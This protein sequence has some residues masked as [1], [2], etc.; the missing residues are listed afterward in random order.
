MCDL[1]AESLAH[2]GAPA[3]AE[4]LAQALRHQKRALLVIALRGRLRTK[5]SSKISKKH[6]LT[7]PETWNSSAAIHRKIDANCKGNIV[8]DMNLPETNFVE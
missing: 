6:E 1:E 7:A 4:P 3:G 2:D 5:K 8:L